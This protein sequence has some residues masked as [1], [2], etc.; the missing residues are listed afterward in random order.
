VPQLVLQHRRFTINLLGA[1]HI[2]VLVKQN[3][4][5]GIFH[6]QFANLRR[7]RCRQQIRPHIFGADALRWSYRLD[8]I[9]KPNPMINPS[10]VH[11]TGKIVAKCLRI[12][13]SIGASRR[14][15]RKSPI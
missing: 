3:A 8:A 4:L 1:G 14:R 11:A 13:S 15:R 10:N 6:Q 5:R 2:G 12:V 7:L 9:E